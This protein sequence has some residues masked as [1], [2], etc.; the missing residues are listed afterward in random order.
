MNK[1]VSDDN[2]RRFLV[3]QRLKTASWSKVSWCAISAHTNF[4][5]YTQFY[6]LCS[7]FQKML[8]FWHCVFCIGGGLQ[9]TRKD[10]LFFYCSSITYR[11]K[12]I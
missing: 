7:L 10:Q 8:Y 5:P 1:T 3:H 9:S 12:T 11:T 2:I 6:P 4:I